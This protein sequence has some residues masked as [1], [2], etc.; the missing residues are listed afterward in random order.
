MDQMCLRLVISVEFMRWD[1]SFF[2]NYE[3]NFFFSLIL[4]DGFWISFL[5]TI[6]VLIADDMNVGFGTYMLFRGFL[7]F[8]E[9][10]LLDN[11]D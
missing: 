1:Q 8:A 5:I 10:T 9:F 11:V 2:R 6:T 3:W 7:A 4:V